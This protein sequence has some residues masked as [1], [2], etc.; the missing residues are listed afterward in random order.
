MTDVLVLIWLCARSE[1]YTEAQIVAVSGR[2]D[3]DSGRS[4][5]RTELRKMQ[6]DLTRQKVSFPGYAFNKYV[7]LQLTTWSMLKHSLN[8]FGHLDIVLHHTLDV[9][10][11]PLYHINVHWA[12]GWRVMCRT[13]SGAISFRNCVRHSAR[14]LWIVKRSR[15]NYVTM[16]PLYISSWFNFNF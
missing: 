3:V 9:L 12:M 2:Y 1:G 6:A 14:G 10:R 15:S 4:I 16:T 11:G 5:D 13:A 8:L 7:L